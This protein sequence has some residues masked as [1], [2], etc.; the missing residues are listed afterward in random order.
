MEFFKLKKDIK[1]LSMIFTV[2][3]IAAFSLTSTAAVNPLSK[4]DRLFRYGESS[5]RVGS[6]GGEVGVTDS[7]NALNGTKLSLGI[8]AFLSDETEFIRFQ[9]DNAGKI[10][11]DRKGRPR[12]LVTN[13]TKKTTSFKRNAIILKP[14]KTKKKPVEFALTEPFFAATD[15]RHTNI[16]VLH[17]DS[18]K[19]NKADKFP[20]YFI[21]DIK[22]RTIKLPKKYGV[23]ITKK[24]GKKKKE[25]IGVAGVF[26]N[27]A[28][29]PVIT[30][31]A[32]LVTEGK[33][34]LVQVLE[35]PNAIIDLPQPLKVKD[36]WVAV[37]PPVNISTFT[38]LIDTTAPTSLD[39]ATLSVPIFTDVVSALGISDSDIAVF[40]NKGSKL[41]TMVSISDTVS[42]DT[43]TGIAK[44]KNVKELGTYQA[45]GKL[46]G[47]S[48]SLP[49]ITSLKARSKS[50]GNVEIK[51]TVV[52]VDGDKP[53]IK[54]EYRTNPSV[55]GSSGWKTIKTI[56]NV[57]PSAK[58]AHKFTWKSKS[59]I[60]KAAG[61]FQI[62]VT[63]IKTINGKS[64]RGVFRT[65][66]TFRIETS[67]GAPKAPDKLKA[68]VKNDPDNEIDA[69]GKDT[70]PP[71][72][73]LSWNKPS[74][75]VAGYNVY[76][77]ARFRNGVEDTFKVIKT[78]NDSST[79]SYKDNSDNGTLTTSFLEAYYTVTA[80]DSS[81]KE[82]KFAK[83]LSVASIVF[84]SY[85]Y[86]G[87]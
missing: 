22:Y 51:Y 55:D 75:N 64:V 66:E 73:S 8:D 15:F 44:I 57:K 26:F 45:L 31:Y 49:V 87:K 42:I 23:T 37:G 79:T 36:G 35:V 2:I 78:I 76:R 39:N 30:T 72:V 1:I 5:L 65:S 53:D 14:K 84:G 77:Q 85:Y 6:L 21:K 16:L 80:F 34:L 47:V 25:K 46:S 24:K 20:T 74:G 62:R 13:V 10:K 52:D 50:N 18:D 3:F 12:I 70:N 61:Y 86:Y 19:D 28:K 17:I 38:T 33:I 59:D 7:T 69:D 63:P 56:N 67:K 71:Q 60:G 68:K 58:K 11:K 29:F 41:K 54:I 9:V 48:K 43:I 81:G 27:K 32:D 40:R 82:S 83:P 4:T